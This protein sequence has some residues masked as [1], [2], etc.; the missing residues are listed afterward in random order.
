M[1]QHR[2]AALPHWIAEAREGSM[3][4]ATCDTQS[5]GKASLTPQHC[6][7]AMENE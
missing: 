3:T 6:A 5:D 2:F 4:N 1:L 7:R